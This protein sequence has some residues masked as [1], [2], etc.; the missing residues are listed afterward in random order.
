MWKAIL[1]G[2]LGLAVAGCGTRPA[3]ITDAERAAAIDEVAHSLVTQQGI[4]G[5]AIAVLRDGKPFRTVTLGTSDLATGAPVTTATPFQLSSTTKLLSST[6]VLLLVADGKVRLDAGIGDYL[7]GLPPAWQPV[8]VRQLLSHTSG[9]PDITRATGEIDLVADDWAHALPI[10]AQASFQFA[11]GHGWSY[12]QTNYALLQRLVERVSGMGFEAFLDQR[13]FAPLGMDHT[14]FPGAGRECATS[15]KRAAKGTPAPRPEL[16]FPA[17]VHAAGGLCASLDDLATWSRALEAGTVIPRPL[18]DAARTPATLADGSTAMVGGPISYGLGRAIDTTPG[19]RWAG[20]SGGNSTAYRRYLDDGLTIIVLH[21]GTHDPDA[22]AAAV[23]R[24]MLQQTAGEGAQADLWDAA[25]AGDTA[26]ADTALQAGA[27]VNALDTRSARSGRRPLNWAALNDNAGMIA[28][29]LAHGADIDATNTT[30]FTA[31]HHAAESGSA[32][33]AA[34]LLDAGADTTLRNAQ[35]ETAADVARRKGHEDLARR[36]AT[37][38]P[39]R[40]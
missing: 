1:V 29:L 18:L 13:L 26:A 40:R 11:P 24:A 36:L 20:H 27:D 23:A 14:F 19:H 33:A 2:V 15:Y 12:T 9:L 32:D 8:T 7:D 28:W 10:V 4:P 21:N 37:A 34:A 22:I 39:G 30:G 17:Y 38:R 16:A 25:V 31:L 3:P 5:V 35:G 6:G